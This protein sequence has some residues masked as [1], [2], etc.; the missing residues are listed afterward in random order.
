MKHFKIVGPKTTREFGIE[1]DEL[2]AF[3]AFKANDYDNGLCEDKRNH[4]RCK[5]QNE[6]IYTTKHGASLN[7]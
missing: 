6:T 5:L 7:D 3:N 4:F 2:L 1:D